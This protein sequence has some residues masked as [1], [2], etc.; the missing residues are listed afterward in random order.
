[1]HGPIWCIQHWVFQKSRGIWKGTST[2]FMYRNREQR[3][4][5]GNTCQTTGSPCSKKNKFLFLWERWC[6]LSI[7]A[8]TFTWGTHRGAGRVIAPT[9]RE[10]PVFLPLLF[11][12]S[13]IL[14]L[15]VMQAGARHYQWLPGKLADNEFSSENKA[16]IFQF[17]VW[18]KRRK[19]FICRE[20]QL[21]WGISVTQFSGFASFGGSTLYRESFG[22]ILPLCPSA[23][24]ALPRGHS[25]VSASCSPCKS[26]KLHKPFHG[27]WQL[28]PF[29][30]HGE[31]TSPSAGL[32]APFQ[33]S[34]A[35]P[36]SQLVASRLQRVP[37]L[38]RTLSTLSYPELLSGSP[39]LP[40]KGWWV[41]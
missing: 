35:A 16:D 21:S 22:S 7:E 33:P 8:A 24:R 12:T 20:C 4:G 6:S 2:I 39:S 15:P 31:A 18:T 27:K 37:L 38:C 32:P 36:G 14:G 34:P 26:I 10:Q 13:C 28:G 30:G 17:C 40:D 25:T 29:P 19:H 9:R 3:L 23:G 41:H 1:M 5:E 11:T